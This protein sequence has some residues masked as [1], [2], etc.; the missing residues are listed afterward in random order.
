MEE[1]CNIVPNWIL[2]EAAAQL[3]FALDIFYEV[4]DMNDLND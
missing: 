2:G 1:S 4:Y 3:S